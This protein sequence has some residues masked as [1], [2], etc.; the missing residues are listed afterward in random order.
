MEAVVA[1]EF[2]MERSCKPTTLTGG[3]DGGTR[4]AF[5]R[6]ENLNGRPNFFNKRGANEEGVEGCNR[7]VAV[8]RKD[9]HIE[10]GFKTFDLPSKGVALDGDVH[11]PKQG[12]LT[13]NVFGEKDGPGTGAPNGML[14][15]KSLEGVDEAILDGQFTNGRG[16][17][18]GEDEAL[19]IFEIAREAHLGGRDPQPLK[20]LDVFNESA[21]QG[22]DADVH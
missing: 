18:A 1:G 17:T 4:W 9:G 19:Q 10:I 8:F 16:F 14:L 7:V 6:G 22:E 5:D 11:K 2:G 3:D 15:P 12:L 20:G 13:M 21:L